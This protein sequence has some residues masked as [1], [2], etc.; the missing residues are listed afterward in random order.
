MTFT[1]PEQTKRKAQAMHEVNWSA[2]VVQ[3]IERRIAV[4]ALEEFAKDSRLTQGDVDEISRS[5]NKSLGRHYRR[6]LGG[7]S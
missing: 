2:V 4:Q 3:A 7:S 1:V 6:R 5:I